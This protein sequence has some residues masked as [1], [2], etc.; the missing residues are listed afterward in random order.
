[1]KVAILATASFDETFYR[2]IR[3]LPY[4]RNHELPAVKND[5]YFQYLSF[6]Q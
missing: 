3:A 1:M 6:F 5:R 2:T 4:T